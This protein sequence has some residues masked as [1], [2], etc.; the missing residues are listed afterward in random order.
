MRFCFLMLCALSFTG[1]DKEPVTEDTLITRGR[2][3]FRSL[4][5]SSDGKTSCVTCHPEGH[6]D[7]RNWHF[8]AIHD[9][10]AGIPDSFRTITLW[11]IA[12]TGSPY[13]WKNSFRSLESVTR[14][15]TD[16]IMGGTASEDEVAALVAYQRSLAFPKNPNLADNGQLTEAQARGKSI[17]EDPNR[18][19]CAPCHP[20]PTYGS[21]IPKNIY[22]GGTFR[23]VG[24]RGLY[25]I[26][27]YFHNGSAKTLHEVIEHYA[28]NGL[29]APLTAQERD[30]LVE[31]L[32]T[33]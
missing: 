25:S 12:Q 3:L 27:P 2:E 10:T 23:T 6:T 33:L 11:G 32:K 22:T 31:Y 17:Y 28:G 21:P 14:L 5:F 15:Y 8:A 20:A 29:I 9:T 4:Q 30:D 1:C 13:L 16:T 7:N 24:L 19:N 26:A 18:G